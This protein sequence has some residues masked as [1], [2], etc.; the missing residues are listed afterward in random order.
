MSRSQRTLL[1]VLATAFAAG[2]ALLALF[3]DRDPRGLAS[4][5]EAAAAAPLALAVPPPA[6]AG[7]AAP[8]TAAPSPAPA[9]GAAPLRPG[10]VDRSPQRA[11]PPARRHA[12][13]TFRRELAGGMVALQ[14][15]AQRCAPRDGQ[16]AAVLVALETVEGG[17]R[18]I[19][20]RPQA[21]GSATDAEVS[22]ARAALA[23]Q[24]LPAPN[25]EPGRRWQLPLALR[26]GA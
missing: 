22:C 13:A 21:P 9:T 23:G 14:Q 8:A 4:G 26:P 17:I 1:A 6:P 16:A 5:A 25:A 10:G 20:A 12:L 15:R 3:A 18:V 7:P 11:M 24:V 2:L 19:D